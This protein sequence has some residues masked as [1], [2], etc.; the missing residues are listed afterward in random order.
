MKYRFLIGVMMV[1]LCAGL[2][3]Q[4]DPP[5]RIEL[6]T[7]QDADDYH[8][9]L[10]GKEG[11]MVFYEGMKVSNDSTEWVMMHYDTNLQKRY[12]YNIILPPQAAFRKS[13]YDNGKLY[14]LYQDV[15]GKKEVPKTYLSVVDIHERK[16]ERYVLQDIPKFEIASNLKAYDNHAVFSIIVENAYLLF[17]YNFQTGGLQRFAVTDAAIISE[18]FIEIDSFN[19]KVLMGLGVLYGN[20]M[21]VLSVFETDYDGLLLKQVALPAFEDYVYMSM[22]LKQL[23]SS[24]A[25]IIGTYNLASSRKTGAYHSGVYTLIYENSM[26]GYPEFF[27]YTNL[28]KKDT[29]KNGKIKEQ[30]VDLQLLVSDIISNDSCFSLITEVYY[31]EY[32]YNSGYYDNSSYYYGGAYTPPQTYFVGYRYVNAYVT[33]FDRNGELLWDNY[34]PF[35]N[36]LTRRLARRVSLYYTPYGTAIFFPYNSNLTACLMNGYTVVENTE[37]VPIECLYK[38]D[39]VEYSRDLN[40][41]NW[42]DNKFII[43]GYQNIVNNSKSTKGKRYVFFLNKL[44]YR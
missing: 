6:P 14:L 19:H 16:A 27:N 29:L 11:V 12:A 30:A 31:P 7:A 42:Y 43:S 15:V 25:L 26:M 40:M 32:N 23:D 9:T 34:F 13:F 44:E 24:R 39:V 38:K 21:A 22:R 2:R 8:F 35:T 36:I 1:F 3:A 20:K 5:L 33:C 10:M 37:T 18:Q 41:Y 4:S 28:H 17:F